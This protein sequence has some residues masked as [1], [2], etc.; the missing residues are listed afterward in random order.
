MTSVIKLVC[1]KLRNIIKYSLMRK[2]TVGDLMCIMVFF[3]VNA[4]IK[5][6]REQ[7]DAYIDVGLFFSEL[8]KYIGKMD[9]FDTVK[10]L[11]L[12]AVAVLYIAITSKK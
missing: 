6:L 8:Q 4:F 1:H 7:I 5:K 2:L 12:M 10:Y 9:S 11:F 3:I